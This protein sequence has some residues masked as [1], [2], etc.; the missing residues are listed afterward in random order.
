MSCP[1]SLQA[2]NKAL[3]HRA[4]DELFNRYNLTALDRY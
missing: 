1:L 2:A 3:A 4:L